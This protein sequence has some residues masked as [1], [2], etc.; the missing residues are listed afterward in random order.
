MCLYH[1]GG[2]N[3]EANFGDYKSA[4]HSNWALAA[5]YSLRK[6]IPRIA[7]LMHRR[8]FQIPL[9]Q[10]IDRNCVV[11]LECPTDASILFQIATKS[12]N[13]PTPPLPNKQASLLE[14]HVGL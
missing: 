6:A 3:G 5:E 1:G 10:F 7:A 8:E 2:E 4:L 9:F 14:F 11:Y 13:P 12:C